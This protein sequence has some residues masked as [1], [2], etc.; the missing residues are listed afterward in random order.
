LPGS[1]QGQSRDAIARRTGLGSGRTYDT[2]VK[3]WQAASEGDES[4]KELVAEIDAGEK[5]ISGAYKELRKNKQA[6]NHLTIG[7][8]QNEWYTPAEYIEMARNVMGGIDLD[9]AS[10]DEANETIKAD[11]YYTKQDSGLNYGWSGRVWLNPPYSRDLMSAFIEKLHE[12]YQEG[13]VS[14]AVIVAHNNTD[15]K[16][17]QR[18]AQVS[19][20][21]CF[22]KKRIRFYRDEDLAAPTNGQAFFYLGDF[23][24][25]FAEIFGAIGI[26]VKPI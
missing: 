5:S 2:A 24:D 25:S 19:S 1:S 21:I 9:P 15:T 14:Q 17:F 18:L 11:R 4:A 6:V 13:A 7:T 26:V 10:C 12:E 23:G 8:G 22:P 16:W 20:V 3:I